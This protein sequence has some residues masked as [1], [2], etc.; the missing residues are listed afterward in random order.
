M[1]PVGLIPDSKG[2][3]ACLQTLPIFRLRYSHI[4]FA[5]QNYGLFW[6]KGK[7]RSI[8]NDIFATKIAQY[9]EENY[10]V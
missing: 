4:G 10:S 1:K 7:L 3:G 5:L 6:C 2:L 8:K 9:D